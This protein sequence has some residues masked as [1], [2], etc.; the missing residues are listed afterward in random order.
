MN[1]N[2]DNP[3]AVASAIIL[4]TNMRKLCENHSIWIRNVLFCVI[5]DLPGKKQATEHLMENRI[6]IGNAVKPYYGK[7]AGRIS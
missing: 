4:H 2:D 6:E 5:D 3:A 1:I 7:D